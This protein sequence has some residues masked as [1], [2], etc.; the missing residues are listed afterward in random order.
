MQG[1]DLA[2]NLAAV[3]LRFRKFR[4]ALVADIQEMFYQVKVACNDRNSLRFLWWPNGEVKQQPEIYKM[5]VHLFG[6]TSSPSCA[7]FALRQAAI[8]M[9]QN[10]NHM[11]LLQLRRIFMKTIVC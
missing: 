9:A 3:L 2:N 4:V 5:T 6:A 10:L 1:P 11:S 8:A 7:A